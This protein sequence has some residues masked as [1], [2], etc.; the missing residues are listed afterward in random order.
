LGALT[1]GGRLSVLDLYLRV[2]PGW[3]RALGES[4][5]DEG[6]SEVGEET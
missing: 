4:D 5:E 2:L 6:Q 3:K 1:I